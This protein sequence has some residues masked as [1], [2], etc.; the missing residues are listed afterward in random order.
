MK[1]N[2][3]CIPCFIKQSLEAGRMVQNDK[4]SN[5]KVLNEVMKY[6][7]N[8]SLNKSPPELSKNVHEIIRNITKSNDP[9]KNVKKISNEKGRLLYKKIRKIVI[10]SDDPLLTGIQY[11]IIGNAIDFGTFKRFDINEL[12]NN[13]NKNNFI[14]KA[15]NRFKEI[16]EKSKTILYLADNTG[17]IFFDKILIEELIKKRKIIKYAVKSNPIINDAL[18][19]DA[20]FAGIDKIADIIEFDKGQKK[21]SPGVILKNAS[22]SFQNI[23]NSADMIIS[24]GQGNY[25]SLNNV[26]REIFFLL[27]I[28]CPLVASNVGFSE[29]SL[30]F[31]V[32]K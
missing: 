5:E 14:N 21:S 6:L 19:E 3:D 22:E 16:L 7:Q 32:N 15:Y 8:I 23:F 27:M 20:E 4:K 11:S 13:G 1:T 24:K 28:K 2:L 25:E 9:Y 29:G 18:F 31:M 30:L 17:E 26:N 10:N 12:I